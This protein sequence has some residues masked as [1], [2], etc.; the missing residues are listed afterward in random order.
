MREMHWSWEDLQAT[1]TYVRRVTWD[2]TQ[3]RLRAE[4]DAHDRAVRQA[5]Q[6]AAH[7]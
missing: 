7:G 6:E 3:I 1:P 5:K 4:A 2:L